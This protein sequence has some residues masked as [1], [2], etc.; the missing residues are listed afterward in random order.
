[1]S[2]ENYPTTQEMAERAAVV[3]ERE[4]WTWFD[5]NGQPPTID[6]LRE[7][8]EYLVNDALR[9]NVTC[10]ATGRLRVDVERDA[11]DGVGQCVVSVELGRVHV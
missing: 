6:Q 8:I 2:D 9:P 4:G 5:T 7:T 11:D 10:V 1:M 3:F